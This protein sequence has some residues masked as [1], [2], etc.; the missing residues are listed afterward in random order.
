MRQAKA[1]KII[2]D[3]GMIYDLNNAIIIAN[4][5][6][7]LTYEVMNILPDKQLLLVAVAFHSMLKDLMED[8]ADSWSLE[9]EVLCFIRELM[10]PIDNQTKGEILQ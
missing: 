4:D 10:N 8:E 3:D 5:D 6:D 7:G 1:I 9:Q 2:Y